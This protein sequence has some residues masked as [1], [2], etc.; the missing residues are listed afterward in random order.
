MINYYEI[1]ELKPNAEPEAIKESID[2]KK[3]YCFQKLKIQENDL[4]YELMIEQ[5]NQAQEILLD[6]IKRIEYNRALKKETKKSLLNEKLCQSQNE[7]YKA[8]NQINESLEQSSKQK[9]DLNHQILSLQQQL[10]TSDRNNYCSDYNND[11]CLER[12]YQNQYEYKSYYRTDWQIIEANL[13]PDLFL[14]SDLPEQIETNIEVV[15]VEQSYEEQLEQYVVENYNKHPASFSIN[16]IEV[17]TTN[18]SIEA[19]RNGNINNII[20][21]ITPRGNY[22][23]YSWEGFHY[24]I[25]K[26]QPKINPFQLDIVQIIFDCENYQENYSRLELIKPVKVSA[27]SGEQWQL[28]KR[29]IIRFL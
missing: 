23:I 5:L 12:E 10:E 7:I 15:L 4:K 21:E 22:W 3:E 13:E 9:I 14:E 24:L 6:S 2:I 25:P 18:E 26:D 19:S 27:L 1:L 16:T 20:F 11:R 8:F 28:D 17:S 29:G